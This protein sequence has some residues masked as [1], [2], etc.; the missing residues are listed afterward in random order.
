MVVMLLLVV[1]N[2]APRTFPLQAPRAA[3]A[4][5]AAAAANIHIQE[6]APPGGQQAQKLHNVR[7]L[8][9]VVRPQLVVRDMEVRELPFEGADDSRL[10]S[11][12]TAQLGCRS[13]VA[14]QHLFEAG[15]S[16]LANVPHVCNGVVG[17]GIETVVNFASKPSY[18]SPTTVVVR[19]RTRPSR[20]AGRSREGGRRG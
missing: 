13:G 15:G 12:R 10:V 1:G 2:I 18:S 17:V 8:L 3:T 19:Q 6:L 5:A 9:V 20:R 11:A 16:M 4:A 14:G 7:S